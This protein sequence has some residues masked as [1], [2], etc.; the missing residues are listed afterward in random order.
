MDH[1][2][3]VWSSEPNTKKICTS[4]IRRYVFRGMAAQF[5]NHELNHHSHLF[6][7]GLIFFL[8]VRL[9]TDQPANQPILTPS[10]QAVFITYPIC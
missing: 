7:V 1:S 4:Q 5:K 9:S 8:L 10:M 6:R 2:R 3:L